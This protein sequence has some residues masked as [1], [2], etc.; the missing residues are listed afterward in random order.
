MIIM[1]MTIVKGGINVYHDGDYIVDI[2]GE[3]ITDKCPLLKVT[4]CSTDQMVFPI[5]LR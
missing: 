2:D 4:L 1:T 3:D 5:S